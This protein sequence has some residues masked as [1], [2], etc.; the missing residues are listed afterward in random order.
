MSYGNF[1]AKV[2]I[3]N[4]PFKKTHVELSQFSCKTFTTKKITDLP[5]RF[6]PK[7][8]ILAK[9]NTLFWQQQSFKNQQHTHNQV[10]SPCLE[11]LSIYFSKDL[12]IEIT[13]V[14]KI[15]YCRINFHIL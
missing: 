1:F 6:I 7:Q 4:H 14:L 8:F 13:T 11:V 3:L 2:G 10:Y 12:K 15:P 5:Y 9:G